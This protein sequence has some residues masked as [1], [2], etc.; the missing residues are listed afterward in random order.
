MKYRN[1][2]RTIFSRITVDDNRQSDMETIETV[3]GD[4]GELILPESIRKKV[5]F[6][7]GQRVTL[8]VQTGTIVIFAEKKYIAD[9]FRELAQRIHLNDYHS[10]EYYD[11]MMTE[12][13]KR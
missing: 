2:V 12:Q 9:Q 10:D 8:Q 3:I 5:H 11:Q 13:M 6:T 7:P 1:E 4:H